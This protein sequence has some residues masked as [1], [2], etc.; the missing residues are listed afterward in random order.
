MPGGDLIVHAKTLSS[1]SGRR[2]NSGKFYLYHRGAAIVSLDASLRYP[3]PIR[4]GPKSAADN[5]LLIEP[6]K[7]E[8]TERGRFSPPDRTRAPAWSHPVIANG[9]LYVRDQETLLCYD[10]KK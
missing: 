1:G 3:C 6:N 9:K 5:M 4:G 10:V 2:G 8:Y 7:Q